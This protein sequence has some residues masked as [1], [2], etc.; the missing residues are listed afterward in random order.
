MI[1]FFIVLA[2]ALVPLL[3][4]VIA[5]LMNGDSILDYLCGDKPDKKSTR[6]PNEKPN[7]YW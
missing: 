6:F 2:L 7:R 3:I 4:V 5:L 1:D